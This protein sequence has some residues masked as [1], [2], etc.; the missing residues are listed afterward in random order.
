[1]TSNTKRW[2]DVVKREEKE[3]KLKDFISNYLASRSAE[4][5]CEPWRLVARSAESPVVLALAALAPQIKQAGFDIE[6][7]LTHVETGVADT[8]AQVSLGFSGEVRVTHDVRLLD[9][10][11]Q[12]RLD[13]ANA[14]VGDCMRR[15]PAK[16]DGYERYAAECPQTADWVAKSFDRLWH[17][18]SPMIQAQASVP[19]EPIEAPIEETCVPPASPVVSTIVVST[20]H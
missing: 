11:E 6:A 7:L 13:A 4:P 20:R 17:R 15:E 14:W 12:L 10:H 5:G 19:A 3:G 1:M 9:A 8:A 2:M 18:G 16:R